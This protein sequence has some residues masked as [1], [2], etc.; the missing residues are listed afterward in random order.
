MAMHTFR[1]QAEKSTVRLGDVHAD[2]IRFLA[3]ETVELHKALPDMK[4]MKVNFNSPKPLTPQGQPQGSTWPPRQ[5]RK[6]PR[7]AMTGM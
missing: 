7:A 1:D 2:K 5:Y 4:A 6:G 3:G